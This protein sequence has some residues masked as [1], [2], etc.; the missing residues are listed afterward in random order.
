MKR[1]VVSLIVGTSEFKI[2][3]SKISD[4]YRAI[5]EASEVLKVDVDLDQ[6]MATLVQI[7][8]G[9]MLSY[10]KGRIKIEILD[11]DNV[12]NEKEHP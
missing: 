1:F 6:A 10:E 8:S 4:A 3:C 7:D 12:Q 9:D 11:T 2:E 5:I